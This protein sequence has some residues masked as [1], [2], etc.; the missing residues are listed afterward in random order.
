M[1]D[2]LLVVVAWKVDFMEIDGLAVVIACVVVV[3]DVV[4]GDVALAVVPCASQEIVVVLPVV[5]DV[6]I[7]L[8][9]AGIAVFVV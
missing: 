6:S 3:D 5:V 4:V 1:V 7:K 9:Y 2:R 8:E